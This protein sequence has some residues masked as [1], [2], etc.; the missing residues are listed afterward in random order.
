[1]ID[2][3]RRRRKPTSG[4]AALPR[5]GERAA[6][7]ERGGARRLHAL[8]REQAQLRSDPAACR[9][10]ADLAA[11]GEYAMARHHDRKGVLT[12]H[13]PDV[14]RRAGIAQPRG[15]LTV[16]KRRARRDRARD[17]VD[18]TVERRD[19]AHVELDE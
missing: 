16:G 3:R 12:E 10:A 14:A 1:M 7:E 6:L 18:A 8:D 13:G 11:G 4:E 2:D 15:D 17:L 9:E 19:Q 5:A